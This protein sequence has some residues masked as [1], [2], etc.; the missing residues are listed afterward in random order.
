MHISELRAAIGEVRPVVE[1]MTDDERHRLDRLPQT[2]M[3]YR[4][5]GA[6]NAAGIC[7]SLSST[8]A[9]EFHS[10]PRYQVERPLLL[11][12]TVE[13]SRVVA[14]KRCLNEDKII[15]FDVVAIRRESY[16]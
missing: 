3:V 4:G 6:F 10:L 15:S 8:I 2:I 16:L 11:T 5:C 13:K 7:W 14:L 9:R 12:G 1:M